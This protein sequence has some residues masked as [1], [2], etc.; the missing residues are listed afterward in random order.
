[1]DLKDKI[2]K[3]KIKKII[4]SVVMAIFLWSWVIGVENPEIE[5]P[6]RGINRNN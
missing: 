5:I 4:I 3:N 6:Y 1:M 2:S